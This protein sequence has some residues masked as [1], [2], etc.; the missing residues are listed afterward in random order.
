MSVLLPHNKLLNT[1]STPHFIQSSTTD[2]IDILTGVNVEEEAYDGSVF[3]FV[4]LYVY[5]ELIACCHNRIPE[6]VD[7]INLQAAG[8]CESPLSYPQPQR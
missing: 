4:V 3:H 1:K 7:S 6:L 8:Y 5:G 2:W